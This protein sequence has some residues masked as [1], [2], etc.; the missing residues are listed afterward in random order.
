MFLQN[1]LEIRLYDEDLLSQDDL[2]ST[3]L[4]DLS[5]L[6]L[7]KKD[8]MTFVLNLEVKANKSNTLFGDLT[9]RLV[10][11]SRFILK[12]SQDPT[13]SESI[14]SSMHCR[15]WDLVMTVTGQFCEKH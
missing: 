13:C 10:L 12:N 7:G 8:T 14:V 1:V 15:I 9:L 3:I 4:F 5:T 2:I 11:V 6:T